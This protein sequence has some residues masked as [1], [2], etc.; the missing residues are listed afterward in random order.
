MKN[1]RSQE[2]VA[3]ASASAPIPALAPILLIALA[4]GESLLS[5]FQW[6]ELL[7]VRAGGTT[8][9]GVNDVVNCQRV[10]DSGFASSIHKLTGIPVAGHGLVWG[11]AALGLSLAYAYRLLK[12]QDAAVLGAAVKLVALVGVLTVPMLA[13][14]TFSAG[15]VCLT[16]LA[17]YAVVAAFALVALRV[18]PGPV[19]PRET[20]ALK[21]AAVWSVA[22]AAVAF[23][24]LLGP[25]IATPRSDAG[26]GVLSGIDKAPAA[27]VPP[28]AAETGKVVA[29]GLSQRPLT[30]ADRAVVQ[31]I[32]TLPPPEKQRLSNW[33]TMYREKQAP[34]GV[35]P[36]PRRLYGPQDAPMKMV[37]W[38]DIRCGHCKHLNDTMNELKRVAPEG[39]FSVEARNFPLDS[40]CNPHVQMSD[41]LG[42]RCTAA[43][44]MIC[45][46]PTKDYWNVRD[47]LFAAQTSLTKD[48]ILELASAGSMKRNELEACIA[49]AETATKLQE[50]IS[51]AMKY[52]LQGTPL[53]VVNGREGFPGP[54]FLYSM[55]LTGA[56]A[57]SPAFNALPAPQFVADE[58]AGHNH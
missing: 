20:A 45:L 52:N 55:A 48:R 21:G 32:E 15:A 18:V 3:P 23:L 12:K 9:C 25:G 38:V 11:L 33:M 2:N 1:K 26:K 40:E 50:D 54:S 27:T 16:C 29:A 17:T 31:F 10:W 6:M 56:D 41:G 4:A 51:Y 28:R 22:F 42:V 5:L 35:A 47:A 30:D 49:S 8:V 39:S 57:S 24:V 58:H 53:V 37:E 34:S 44:A 7:V 14:A 13:I 19:L 46:E 36:A 43:K